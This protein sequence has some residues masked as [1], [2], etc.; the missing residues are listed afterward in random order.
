MIRS[1]LACALIALAAPATAQ[2]I[3][4]TNGTV[5]TGDGS[6]P[7]QGATVVI[8][9]G[10]IVAAGPGVAVPAGAQVIDASGKWVT[11][12][13]VAGFSR[14]GLSDVDLS[15]DGAELYDSGNPQRSPVSDFELGQPGEGD[16]K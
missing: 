14:L 9:N 12:G 10:R 16:V 4:I 13:I 5:A 15:V 11:P 6:G 3:A 1:A 8:R 2:T 7:M